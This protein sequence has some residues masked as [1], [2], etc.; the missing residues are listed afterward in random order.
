M[1]DFAASDKLIEPS[2][3]QANELS[4][5]VEAL[6]RAASGV[7]RGGSCSLADL[8]NYHDKEFV[9]N[10]YAVIAHRQPKGEELTRALSNL[11]NGRRTKTAIVEELIERHPGVHID[12]VSS[13]VVRKLKRIPFVGYF[14]QILRAIARLPV[15]VQHQQQFESFIIGQQQQMAEQLNDPFATRG[16]EEVAADDSEEGE[17]VSDAIKT[18]MMMSD[19]LIELSTSVAEAEKRL[20]N[21]EQRQESEVTELRSGLTTLTSAIQQIQQQLEKS[22]GQTSTALVSLTRQLQALQQH[23]DDLR[24]AQREFLVNEQR[25]IVEAER[26]AVDDLQKQ[27]DRASLENEKIVAE[28]KAELC[29]LRAAIEDFQHAAFQ[30]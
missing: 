1:K 27:L 19:S 24:T 26:A 15:L 28:L 13:P 25:V 29:Q 7:N 30:K 3:D 2:D 20:L 12:G 23:F 11:R 10:A 5:K 8:L 22:E 4:S 9:L 16:I 18:V 14:L 21:L 17:T 6:P